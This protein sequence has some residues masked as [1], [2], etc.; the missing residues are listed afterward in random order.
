MEAKFGSRARTLVGDD[1]GDERAER[2]NQEVSIS[3]LVLLAHFVPAFSK[4]LVGPDVMDKVIVNGMIVI[5]VS[6]VNSSASA[7]SDSDSDSDSD[8]SSHRQE[9]LCH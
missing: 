7:D 1:H 3:A 9:C 6:G 5:V 8:F 2:V 4:R